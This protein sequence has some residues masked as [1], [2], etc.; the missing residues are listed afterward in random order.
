M[1]PVFV[2]ANCFRS[3]N[4]GPDAISLVNHTVVGENFNNISSYGGGSHWNCLGP[5]GK[6]ILYCQ[7][8]PVILT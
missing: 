2:V 5:L 7:I 8:L 1:H 3:C 6:I 4:P